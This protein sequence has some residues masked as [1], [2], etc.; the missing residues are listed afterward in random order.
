MSENTDTK[1]CMYCAEL[2]KKEAVKC[3]YCG[4]WLEQGQATRWR[5]SRENKMI[6]GI[7]AGLAKQFNIDVTLVRI[8]FIIAAFL[9]WGILLYLV[10]WPLIPWEE[11]KE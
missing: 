5:R 6:L 4:S 1:K 2:I 9:G 3:R 8:G 7:C 10:L 11:K